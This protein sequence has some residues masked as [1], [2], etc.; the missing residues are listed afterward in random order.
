MNE[1]SDPHTRVW[2]I[3]HGEPSPESRGRCYG[4]LDV[5]LSTEGRRQLQAVSEKLRGEAIS[6]I[7]SSPRKRT[8]ES[9]EILAQGHSSS[10]T[11]EERLCEI[12][13]G[14]F[15]GRP[16][17]EIAQTHPEIYTQWME[18]PTE[19]QFPNG[20]SFRQM[21]Q[22]VLQ[23]ANE[24]YRRH[25]GNTIAI[26]SHGGV[27]RILLAEAV[28]IPA[29]NIFRIAQHYAAMNLLVLIGNYPSVELVNA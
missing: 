24:I 14:D 23:A 4:R 19:T 16:Y 26:V 28:A 22:R 1:L 6:A 10:I 29:L 18:H 15:E 9:A 2:L 12:D 17:D 27:N 21:Q 8:V 5:G 7:Y 20:E 11:I 3:R 13:F 25:R